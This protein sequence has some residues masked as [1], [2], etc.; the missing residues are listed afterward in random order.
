MDIH[1][2]FLSILVIFTGADH[3]SHY[4]NENQLPSNFDLRLADAT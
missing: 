3:I 2:R 1:G 4:F